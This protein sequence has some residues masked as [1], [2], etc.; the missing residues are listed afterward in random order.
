MITLDQFSSAFD[1]LVEPIWN[2]LSYSELLSDEVIE[3]YA[4]KLH[5]R[6]LSQ[7]QYLSEEM[8]RKFSR[9]VDWYNIVIHQ[10]MSE[11]LIEEFSNNLRWVDICVYQKLSE[12]FIEKHQ[13][14]VNWINICCYQVLS[15]EFIEKHANEVNWK[16]IST[17]QKLSETFIE[18][19]FDKIP[20]FE[21]SMYQKL[22]DEFIAK[23][24]LDRF[25]GSWLYWTKEEKLAYI[26]ENCKGVYELVNDEYVIAYKSVRLN[27]YPW[28]GFHRKYEIGKE[29]NAHCDCDIGNENSFGIVVRSKEDI[30]NYKAKGKLLK[31]HINIDDIGVIIQFDNNKIRAR[32]VLVVS[33][34]V[35]V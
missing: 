29:C 26:K 16:F 3:K 25:K 14:K 27:N 10:K 18:K 12:S 24:N 30:E 6:E 20:K 31:V 15:E 33:E 22:S 2:K 28:R 11:P 1:S 35:R 19:H 17:Y 32:K 4:D 7:H 34:E 23:H 5:W 8:I 21:L 13:D 9:K